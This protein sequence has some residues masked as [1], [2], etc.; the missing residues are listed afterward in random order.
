MNT[1]I[2]IKDRVSEVEEPIILHVGDEVS[3]L[4]ESDSEGDW[5]GWILCK[6]GAVEGWIP[7]Q[8]I[9]IEGK[10]GI[11]TE[12]YSALEFDIAEG[13][14]IHSLR[15]LNGWIWGYKSG[16]PNIYA[17]APLNHLKQLTSEK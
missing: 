16:R 3:C 4:K 2:V 1:Y 6:A 9:N 12:D 7:S 17:W 8:I 13:E 14:T 10:Q 5:S 11:V 15:S